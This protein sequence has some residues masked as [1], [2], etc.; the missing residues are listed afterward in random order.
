MTCNFSPLLRLSF[1]KVSYLTIRREI[2]QAHTIKSNEKS[3]KEKK[4]KK[5]KKIEK[6]SKQDSKIIH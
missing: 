3:M 1:K 5:R 6:I 2:G 4:K